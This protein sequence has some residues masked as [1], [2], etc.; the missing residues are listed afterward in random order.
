[1]RINIS[2]LIYHTPLKKGIGHRHKQNET[3][4]LSSQNFKSVVI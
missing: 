2:Y 1:V 4:S 3:V